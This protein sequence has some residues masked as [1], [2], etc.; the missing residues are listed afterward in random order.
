MM[1][2]QVFILGLMLLL[3]GAVE[4]YVVVKRMVGHPVILPCTYSTVHG[5][6]TTCWGRG[7]CPFFHC[8]NTLIKT[9]RHSVTYERS[10]QYQLKGHYWRDNT[11]LAMEDAAQSDSG[12][13]CCRVEILGLFTNT[14][15]TVSLEVKPDWNNTVTSSEDSWD[16]NSEA[17]SAQKFR[18]NMTKGFYVGIS[19][20]ALVLL[21]LLS[22][23]V[24]TKYVIM[25]K[26]SESL[27]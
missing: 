11:S 15:V 10:S 24:I 26:K 14:K 17:I 16:Y 6:T 23:M 27:G 25:T 12:L 8:A 7:E 18:R 9:N 5:L 13:Y 1:H 19:I 20:A 3:L 21:L 2:P 4:T 22:T